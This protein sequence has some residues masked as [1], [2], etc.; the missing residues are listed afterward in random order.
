MMRFVLLCSP[1]V[2]LSTLTADIPL[3]FWNNGRFTNF[4]DQLS[5]EI[6]QKIVQK[7]VKKAE[8][9]TKKKLLAIGS[10][11]RVAKDGDVVWGAG[12]SGKSLDINKYHFTNIDIRAVRGPLTRSFLIKN[13]G[14]ECPEIYGDPALLFPY[15]FPEFKKSRTP[16][17]KYI[18][19]PHFS[20]IHLFRKKRF[21]R[22]ISPLADWRTVVHAICESE[23]V[24]SSSLHGIV[25][26]ESFGIPARLL[27]V[28]ENEPLFKYIDYYM[29]TG[30]EKFTPARSIKEALLLKG[31]PPV[32]CDLKKILNAFPYELWSKK[33]MK[34]W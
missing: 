13:F 33:E 17:Y 14:V 31:E 4:G 26:A 8:E 29:G 34:R 18:V 20:E 23:F 12:V 32:S 6:V 1:F 27:R 7:K 9:H 19:I 10:I 25:I 28:T 30:R 22:V 2:F 3:Y 16:R 21:R 5:Y 24:I 11:L 15:L